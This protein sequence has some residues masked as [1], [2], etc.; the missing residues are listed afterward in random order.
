MRLFYLI[1]YDI[2]T[3]LVRNDGEM[4]Q[5]HRRFTL[6][7]LRDLGFGKNITENKIREEAEF[8]IENIKKEVNEKDSNLKDGTDPR[9]I[10]AKAINNLISNLIFNKRC[11][12]E[13][14][15]EETISKMN[16]FFQNNVALS[17]IYAQKFFWYF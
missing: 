5:T 8:L 14:E 17:N 11:S 3:G 7:V 13:P 9:M 12:M 10:L 1:N 4:W 15:F 6:Q 2:F 16:T